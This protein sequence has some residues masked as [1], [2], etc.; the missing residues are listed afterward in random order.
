MAN[1]QKTRSEKSL[2]LREFQEFQRAYSDPF[3]FI[4]QLKILHP[5]QGKIPFAL[6]PYQ[7]QVEAAFLNHPLTIVKKFRQGG[8]TELISAHCLWYAN[9]R[10]AKNIQILSI[11]DRVAKRVLKR[12]KNMY[13]SSAPHLVQP[14]I[15]GRPGDYGTTTE[16]EFANGS[17]ITSIPTTEDAGRS[18]ACSLF[19]MDEASIIKWASQIWAA[20]FPTISTGGRAIVN[21]CVTGDTLI[22]GQEKTFRIDSVCPK[23]FGKKDI[24]H[25]GLKVLSHTGKWQRVIGSVNKGKLETWEVKDNLGNILKCT[26]HHKLLTPYGWKSVEEI[27][28]DRL[29]IVTYNAGL[30]DIGEIPITIPPKEEILRPIKDFPNYQ[31]SNLGKVYICK[32]GKILKKEGSINSWGYRSIKLWNKCQNKKL[33]ISHIVAEA[34]IGDIPEGYVVDHINCNK[35]DDYVTNLQIITISENGLRAV[36]YSR[37][38][39]LGCKIGKGFPNLQLIGKIREKAITK[40]PD[41]IIKECNQEMGIKVSRAFIS[42]LINN[43]RTETVQISRL[44]L[45]KKYIDNIYDISVE[46]DESYLSSSNF[47]NHNTPFGIGNLY[48]KLWVDAMAGGNGFFPI[49]LKWDM[50]PDRDLAW[51]LMMKQAL[52]PRRTAQEI[53]GDFLSSGNSVFDLVDIK[54]IEDEI[55]EYPVLERRLNGSLIIYKRPQRGAIYTLGGDVSTGRAHD[56][57]AFTVMDRKGEEVAVFKGKLPTHKFRDLCGETGKTYNYAKMAVEGNDIGEGINSN[58]QEQ[59]Y[60]NMYYH[61]ELLKEKGKGRPNEKKVPGWMTTTSNRSLI[62]DELEN[63]IREESIICKD[64]FFVQEAYTF[65]YDERNKP[66]ALGKGSKKDDAVDL[67]NEDTY[68]DD[69]IMGKAICNFVRKGKISTVV[70]SPQ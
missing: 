68:T 66:V 29:Y 45:V 22:I 56:Y 11:K 57:S 28:D 27:I 65:V 44:N 58:L 9:H 61:I 30:K 32:N 24:S 6:Y 42:R 59:G 41:E 12:I 63:D 39:K 17:L 70:V 18:E 49:N 64:P 3:F 1:S 13:I 53:D 46:A 5:V 35:Q 48:H 10:P 14:I 4:E 23:E 38:I 8:L 54:A 15:N 40:F 67:E 7:K 51:Y 62:I 55:S 2:T 31:I 19:V 20:M 47:I 25:L 60:P 33:T 69:S 50:H 43:R 21:S 36:K 34:F 26:P 37:G 16:L 52:G